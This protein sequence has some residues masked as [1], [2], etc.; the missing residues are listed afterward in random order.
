MEPSCH[1]LPHLAG[2]RRRRDS[3]TV[4]GAMGQTNGFANLNEDDVRQR[5]QD[6]MANAQR[7]GVAPGDMA[8]AV[9]GSL[10]D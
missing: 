9:A 4:S 3:V 8:Q 6:A 7:Q 5:I 10:G 1:R 2:I